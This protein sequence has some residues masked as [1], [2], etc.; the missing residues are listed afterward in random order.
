MPPSIWPT[1]KMTNGSPLQN[2][3][4]PH[5]GSKENRWTNFGI[6][7]RIKSEGKQREKEA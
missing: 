7:K 3:S 1:H 6:L 5:I 2:A 4:M